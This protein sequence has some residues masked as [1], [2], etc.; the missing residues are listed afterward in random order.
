MIKNYREPN[1]YSTV[2]RK[3]PRVPATIVDMYPLVIGTGAEDYA[4]ESVTKDYEITAITKEVPLTDVTADDEIVSIAVFKGADEIKGV[5][6][7][8]YDVG[9]GAKAWKAVLPQETTNNE[10]LTITV[11]IANPDKY[12]LQRFTG[13]GA[14]EE[15]YGPKHYN[16]EINKI[17]LGAQIACDAGSQVVYVLQVKN[18]GTGGDLLEAYKTALDEHVVEIPGNPTW[19]LQPVDDDEDVREYLMEFIHTM[20]ST[21]ERSEKY[22]ALNNSDAADLT[23]VAA[24]TDSFKAFIEKTT[25][26]PNKYS[27]YRCQTF[28]PNKAVYTFE[29]INEDGEKEE[30]DLPVG[31]EFIGIAIAGAEQALE[32]ESQ[33]LTCSTIP[34]Y[35]FKSLKGVKMKRSDKNGLAAYGVTLLVQDEENGAITVRDSLSMDV[36]TEQAA[37]PCITRAVDYGAKYVRAQ[38]HPYLGKYNIDAETISKVQAAATTAM[39]TLVSKKLFVTAEVV[40][41]YQNEDDLTNIIVNARFGVSYPLKTID[42]NIVCD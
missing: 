32:R 11:G 34:A 18:P 6:V 25:A 16:G 37:D 10:V 29:V 22:T 27:A 13:T 31:G 40:E 15:F 38:L 9:E 1:V 19:R 3:Q 12:T 24:V 5:K 41:I 2:K 26:R 23:T 4:F 35:I 20:S 36:S 30:R 8:K 14:I 33:S 42:V 39:S 17:S 28:Y 7:E 21:E